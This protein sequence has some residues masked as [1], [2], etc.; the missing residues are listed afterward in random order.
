M[1]PDEI[2]KNVASLRAIAAH[3]AAK[4]ETEDEYAKVMKGMVV[5]IAEIAFNATENTAEI[6]ERLDKLIEMEEG[7]NDE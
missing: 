2:R 7:K 4:V 1:K 6:C 5:L 3:E